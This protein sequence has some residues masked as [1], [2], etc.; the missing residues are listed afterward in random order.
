Q[1]GQRPAGMEVEGAVRVDRYLAVLLADGGPERL[2]LHGRIVGRRHRW[3]SSTCLAPTRTGG[4]S[5]ALPF[6]VDAIN[7]RPDRQVGET[8]KQSRHTI[9]SDSG[10]SLAMAWVSWG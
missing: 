7:L 3:A 5:A 8:R 10:P 9:R 4:R 1:S 2:G 6:G